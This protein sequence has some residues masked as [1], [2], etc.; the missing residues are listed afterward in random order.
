MGGHGRICPPGFAM[1]C[2]LYPSIP[3]MAYI[4]IPILSLKIIIPKQDIIRQV[5]FA[6]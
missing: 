3:N 2:T 6:E 4:Y 1:H 5:N